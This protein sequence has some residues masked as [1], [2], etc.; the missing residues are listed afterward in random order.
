MKRPEETAV[1]ALRDFIQANLAPELSAIATDA[2]DGVALPEPKAYEVTGNLFAVAQKTGY[3]VLVVAPFESERDRSEKRSVVTAEVGLLVSNTD[4]S[5]QSKL[6]LRYVMAAQNIIDANHRL[7]PVSG[8]LRADPGRAQ[9]Y[10]DLNQS[11][12]VAGARFPVEIWV[13]S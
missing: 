11:A 6:V 13:Q 7:G 5:I 4:P 8:I 12:S 2:G 9:Y 1:Y 3:P 10:T